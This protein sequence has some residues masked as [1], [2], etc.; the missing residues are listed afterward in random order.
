MVIA[1]SPAD[2]ADK[3]RA[4]A[5]GTFDGVHLG[6]RRLLSRTQVRA[7]VPT[8]VTFHPH[9][10]V[11]LGR[12]VRL[13]CSL[14]RRLEL[15]IEAG[16]RDVLVMP[17]TKETSMLPPD[18]WVDM[19]LRPI[20]TQRVVVGENY[21]YGHRASGNAQTLRTSGFDVDEVRLAHGASSTRIRELVS[22]GDVA[23]AGCLLGRAPEVE[24]EAVSDSSLRLLRGTHSLLPPSGTYAARALGRPATVNLDVPRGYLEVKGLPSAIPPLSGPVRVELTSRGSA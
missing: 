10:R 23:T 16:I 14:A 22:S 3:P 18:V 20:G 1:S 15:M 6:H 17:F 9:P 19:V 4:V 2:L 13:I 5:V 21:R 8:V 11:V 24:G 12:P 7:L